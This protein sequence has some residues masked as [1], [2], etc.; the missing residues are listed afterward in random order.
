VLPTFL[1]IGARKAGSTSLFR[2]LSG[3]P[4]VYMPPE[5]RLE[6]FSGQTW[7]RGLTWYADQ[8][9]DANGATAIG[10]ASN[11][12]T[13]YPAAPDTPARIAEALPDVRL[14]YL[15]RHPIERI[16][17]QYRQ[18]AAHWGEERPLDEV[19]LE[20]PAQY[21]ALSRY[22]MQID[23]YLQHLPRE[24]LHVIISEDLRTKRVET[25]D[26][27][28]RFI[29]VDPAL[30]PPDLGQDHHLSSDHRQEGALFRRLRNSPA[31]EVARRLLPA[32]VRQAGWRAAT[33][34]VELDPA[35][36]T[37]SETTRAHL[38]VR[39]RP[40]LVRLRELLGPTFHAWGLLD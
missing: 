18:A 5:K 25:L 14:I 22:A 12:Y 11:A 4:Q 3:H 39:L 9:S 40:D 23:R 28:W 19:V 38:L 2:Y 31:R 37:L 13:T 1:V 16:I 15:V 10:E 30:A 21:V 26:R 36:I 17:S 8:F 6:F 33:R 35:A 29:G 24:Q 32:S 20:R 27:L 34:K 7:D